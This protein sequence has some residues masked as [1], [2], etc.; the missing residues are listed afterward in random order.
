MKLY[1][2]LEKNK[3]TI[4]EFARKI[5]CNR[6]LVRYVNCGKPVSQ[7]VSLAIQIFTK[8]EI[9]PEIRNVGRPR[10]INIP[11]TKELI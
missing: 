10:T 2:W 9:K 8:G 3:M 6:H 1:E 4:T 5:G 7:D 11:T